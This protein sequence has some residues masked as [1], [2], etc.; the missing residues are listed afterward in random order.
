MFRSEHI[1]RAQELGEAHWV[2]SD[3]SRFAIGG[4]LAGS[5]RDYSVLLAIDTTAAPARIVDVR[6]WEV[7]P[8]PLLQQEIANFA[9][10]YDA[11]PWLDR[12][13]I[14]WGIAQNVER[15]VVGV[16]FTGGTAE[17]GTR[18]E[19]NIPRTKLIT[20]LVLAL[21]QGQLAIPAQWQEVLLGLRSYRWEKRKARYADHVDA[22]A[23]AWWSASRVNGAWMQ[24]L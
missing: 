19:P 2:R 15:R 3:T 23:L 16:A 24:V 1:A 7:L 12:T 4:D 10:L 8:A 9:D 11:D 13:G 14:G 5:G 17:T 21:E 20:N 6:A 18:N 22:L